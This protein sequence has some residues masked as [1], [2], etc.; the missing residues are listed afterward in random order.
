MCFFLLLLYSLLGFVTE[1]MTEGDR[2]MSLQRIVAAGLAGIDI[3]SR[4][5]SQVSA[6]DRS[7]SRPLSRPELCMH[8]IPFVIVLCFFVLWAVSSE[9]K[10]L[11]PQVTGLPSSTSMDAAVANSGN[12]TS[13]Q[14]PP[15]STIANI[16]PDETLQ[17]AKKFHD[18]RFL[19]L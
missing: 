2:E 4:F 17:S 18:R 13:V 9:V 1:N 7:L 3:R 8:T 12:L 14:S 10:A 11:P 16:I 15:G 19:Q 6:K 5:G